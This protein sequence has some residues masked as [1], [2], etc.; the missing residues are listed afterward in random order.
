MSE[1]LTKRK[2]YG[3]ACWNGDQNLV[4]HS[5]YMKLLDALAKYED[6]LFD[7]DGNEIISLAR[8]RELAKA[9]SEGRLVVLPV[10]RGT[11]FFAANRESGR[12]IE[13]DFDEY[14]LTL[15]DKNGWGY[16]AFEHG[17]A[18]EIFATRAEAKRALSGAG[19]GA[20]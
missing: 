20:E 9:E 13:Q 11:R 10:K 19:E 6:V 2:D 1:R 17:K 4:T 16:V 14:E 8:L 12:V 5:R 15:M 18:S 7:A 3:C